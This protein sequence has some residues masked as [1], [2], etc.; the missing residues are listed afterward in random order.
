MSIYFQ[1][2][3]SAL[4]NFYEND[5]CWRG[6]WFHTTEAAY[7]YEKGLFSGTSDSLLR[8]I[9]C[10]ETGKAAKHLA[11]G[12]NL[13]SAWD[14]DTK[15]AAMHEILQTKV[16]TADSYLRELVYNDHFFEAT[17]D[18]FWGVGRTGEGHNHLGR[19]HR[20]VKENDTPRHVLVLAD[21]MFGGMSHPE[22]PA[23]SAVITSRFSRHPRCR[24]YRSRPHTIRRVSGY[25]TTMMVNPGITARRLRHRLENHPEWLHGV[26]QVVIS[27]GGN[28][29]REHRQPRDIVEDVVAMADMCGLPTTVL[30]VFPMAR[31][32]QGTERRQLNKLLKEKLKFGGNAYFHAAR[33][34]CGRGS[35]QPKRACFR[36]DEIHLTSEAKAKVSMALHFYLATWR[37][38]V[39]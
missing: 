29:L 23:G 12:I 3:L 8:E 10:S 31:D 37:H 17:T 2:R 7:Q 35:D 22:L 15:I 26:Q 27:V 19:L 5:V 16:R 1:G 21:S 6:L 30:S 24:S 33:R 28:D 36:S 39:V 25:T 38:Q 13:S 32:Q 9:L 4:S 34:V 14:N 18:E 11:K 20:L